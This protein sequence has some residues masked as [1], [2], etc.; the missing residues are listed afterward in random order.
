MQDPMRIVKRKMK[1]FSWFGVQGSIEN[2][3]EKN[4]AN[5]TEPLGFIRRVFQDMKGL[6]FGVEGLWSTTHEPDT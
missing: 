1:T 4:M 5:E 3:M 6:G 2:Q